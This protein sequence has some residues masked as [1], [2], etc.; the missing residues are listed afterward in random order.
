MDK[1]DFMFEVGKYNVAV[2]KYSV[3]SL[4]DKIKTVSGLYWGTLW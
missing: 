2:I 4:E 1:V 3:E